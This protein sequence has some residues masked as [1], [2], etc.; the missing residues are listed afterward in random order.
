MG[1]GV[2]LPGPPRPRPAARPIPGRRP[3][4]RRGRPSWP[5][6]ATAQSA[7]PRPVFRAEHDHPRGDLQPAEHRGG[8]PARVDPAGVRNHGRRPFSAGLPP[9]A[10]NQLVQ[11]AADRFRRSRIEAARHGGR[12]DPAAAAGDPSG[13]FA[14]GA[15]RATVPASAAA[16]A[17]ASRPLSESPSKV[18]S[19]VSS[20]IQALRGR[21]ALRQ[22]C[23]RKPRASRWCSTAT[24]GQ[25]QSAGC[26]AGDLQAVLADDD[27]RRR[28]RAAGRH[29]L[30]PPQQPHVHVELAR[31]PPA[32]WAGSGDRRWPRGRPH[33]PAPR[34]AARVDAQESAARAELPAALQADERPVDRRGGRVA[35]DGVHGA[36]HGLPPDRGGHPASGRV[37]TPAPAGRRLSTGRAPCRGSTA[38]QA[39]PR[40]RVVLGGHRA[41]MR[42]RGWRQSAP[43]PA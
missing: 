17:S 32:R 18:I 5:C 26:A 6:G 9:G 16:A 20:S 43:V 22:T 15:L 12:P 2:E 34:P 23:S 36:G 3:T 37:Q 10:A 35:Q 13:S 39:C 27:G 29:R 28:D 19:S 31:V 25:Q 4:R 21:P 1:R 38:G 7:P 33:D 11:L 24:P 30:R 40:R 8:Q 42:R 14:R 41:R